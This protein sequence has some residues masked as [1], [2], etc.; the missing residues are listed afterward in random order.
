MPP[1]DRNVSNRWHDEVPGA[2]WYRTDLHV[3]T[4]D[5]H[6]GRIV[7]P[8]GL[9]GDPTDPCTQT[10]YAR[11]FLQAAI[12]QGIEVLGLTPHAV[13][14]GAD[15]STS[16]T[17]RIVDEWNSGAD[18]D[19]VPFRDKIYAVFP[20]F[21]PNLTAGSHGIHLLIL[22]DPEIGREH[23]VDL[24]TAIMKA[25]PPWVDGQ[26]RLSETTAGDAFKAI[27]QLRTRLRASW[28]W[29]CIAPHAFSDHGLFTLKAETL[30]L[31]PHAGVQG[32]ELKDDWVPA[33]AFADKPFLEQGMKKYKHALLHG[34]DAYRVTDIG[35]RFSLVKLATPRIESLRQA[36]LAADSRIRI[37]F[38]RDAQ[39]QFV[40]IIFSPSL[41]GTPCIL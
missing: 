17:W 20:G 4:L 13:R 12:H 30:E 28:D 26:L 29:L 21:E 14:S 16:A 9:N 25:M 5:D 33:D 32:L 38:V 40:V 37:A 27:H 24:C 3:H 39:G 15:A 34:S 31:F 1:F 35:R 19:G 36:L 10:A 22:F 23:Y 18:D 41:G 7:W 11:A 6:A 2:R 8:A